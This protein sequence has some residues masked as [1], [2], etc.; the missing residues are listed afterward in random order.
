MKNIGIGAL[1]FSIAAM[2]F[3]GVGLSVN[4]FLPAN[5]IMPVHPMMAGM[6]YTMLLA[7]TVVL[8][9]NVGEIINDEPAKPGQW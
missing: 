3:W 5:C 8:C 7:L 1:V 4:Y 6:L 2:V 9:Y